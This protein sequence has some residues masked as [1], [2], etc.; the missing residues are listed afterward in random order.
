[1]ASSVAI[2]QAQS[3]LVELVASG[4]TTKEVAHRVHVTERAV[5]ARLTRLYRRYGAANRAALVAAVL[6]ERAGERLAVGTRDELQ[7]ELFAPY[8]LAPYLVAVTRGPDH[9][10]LCVNDAALAFLGWGRDQV[11]GRRLTEA[12][13]RSPDERAVIDDAYRTGRIAT[14]RTSVEWAR[15]PG[16]TRATIDV[17]AQPVRDRDGRVAGLLLIATPVEGERR[18]RRAP[19]R[20]SSTSPRRGGTR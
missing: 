10:F 2:T 20:P 5:K 6:A 8:R 3:E 17:V 15:G 1:M 9:G 11:V 13:A 4:L 14:T 7:A 19:P 18:P 16:T 12:F